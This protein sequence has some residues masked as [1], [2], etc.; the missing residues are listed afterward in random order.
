MQLFKFLISLFVLI[1]AFQAEALMTEVG[2]SYGYSKKTFNATNF[3]QQDFK[4]ASLSLY[5]YEKF[6]LEL[7][8]TDS[9]YEGQESD[10]TSTRTVQQ[11]SKI[12][13]GSLVYMLLGRQSAIQPY[14]KGGAAYTK[15]DEI[16]KYVNASGIA[17]PES[18]GWAPS[19]GAGL[20]IALTERFSLKFSYDVWQTPLSDG[21]NSDDSS[22]RA[23][24]SWY[25]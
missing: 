7:S 16:I 5:F 13:D 17:I 2:L 1:Y 22:F 20:K 6:A 12:S 8:Y 25:L 23:G 18:A 15:K 10:T 3:Y 4:S 9:F 11:S 19:Y 14:I 21:T 24:L